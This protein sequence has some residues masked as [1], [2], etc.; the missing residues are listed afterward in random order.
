M[1]K[2]E[3]AAVVEAQM[4]LR[5]HWKLL[6]KFRWQLTRQMVHQDEQ[7]RWMCRAQRGAQQARESCTGGCTGYEE[8]LKRPG[9]VAQTGVHITKMCSR[10]QRKLHKRVYRAQ[11]SVEEPSNRCPRGFR[12]GPRSLQ[13]CQVELKRHPRGSKL[14]P[15]SVQEAPS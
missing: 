12:L 13:N 6:C 14:G 3:S 9:R 4:K 11:K 2:L 10:G 8:V 1:Y 7:Y 15:R 5:S